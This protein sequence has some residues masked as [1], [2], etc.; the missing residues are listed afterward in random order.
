MSETISQLS[1]Q[2]L[3]E[4]QNLLQSSMLPAEDC[5]EQADH[6]Y[7]LYRQGRMLAAGGLEPASPYLLLRS[8]VVGVDQRGQGLGERMT[9]FLIAQA[10]QANC[11]AIYLLTETAQAYFQRF[12]FS[13]VD[14]DRVPFPIKQTRQFS[15]LCPDTA[16]CM[17]LPLSP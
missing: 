10:R 9:R 17:V 5:A 15:G 4:L 14:R 7:A 3:D 1:L 6:I 11:P 2:D 13:A 8:V 12:G 16:V